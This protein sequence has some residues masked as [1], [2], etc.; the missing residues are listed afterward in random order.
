MDDNYMSTLSAHQRKLP[1]PS[2]SANTNPNLKAVLIKPKRKLPA[3]PNY[4]KLNRQA[5]DSDSE[6]TADDSSS[7]EITLPRFYYFEEGRAKREDTSAICIV[8][9]LQTVVDTLKS[10]L[11]LQGSAVSRTQIKKTEMIESKLT[12]L[13]KNDSHTTER[14]KCV[15]GEGGV[16]M[17][18]SL[19]R[20]NNPIHS[21]S[22]DRLSKVKEWCSMS[23][24]NKMTAHMSDDHITNKPV[25]RSIRSPS[26]KSS[27]TWD[28]SSSG[29]SSDERAEPR[30]PPTT[31]SAS[32]SVSSKTKTEIEV[33]HDDDISESDEI[34]ASSDANDHAMSAS[35]DNKTEFTNEQVV[36]HLE[37]T[38]SG[39]GKHVAAHKHADKTCDACEATNNSALDKSDTSTLN[40]SF[41]NAVSQKTNVRRPVLPIGSTLS[42]NSRIQ[43]RK[44]VSQPVISLRHPH[45]LGMIDTNLDGL[46][47]CGKSLQQT[48]NSQTFYAKAE[49]LPCDDAKFEIGTRSEACTPSSPFSAFEKQKINNTDTE[50]FEPNCQDVR[51]NILRQRCLP[52]QSPRSLKLLSVKLNDDKDIRKSLHGLNLSRNLSTGGKSVPIRARHTLQVSGST[53]QPTSAIDTINNQTTACTNI[54]RTRDPGK[55]GVKQFSKKMW[56]APTGQPE[57]AQM[58]PFSPFGGTLPPAKIKEQEYKKHES[59]ETAE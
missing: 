15:K 2:A 4:T 8:P 47:V 49:S 5:H 30:S 36:N 55:F 6:N 17:H 43:F 1:I 3:K 50:K 52:V 35:T 40:L 45:R 48:T 56:R 7:N 9:K 18:S 13:N 46:E 10:N 23:D 19:T 38:L 39:T 20:E 12:D 59:D 27:T 22:L 54:Q 28:R 41:D 25:E 16:I 33:I 44:S 42:D 29:Y 51:V 21:Y 37:S 57:N 11:H 24:R 31:H 58:R 32:A 26:P 14:N 53:N 34:V